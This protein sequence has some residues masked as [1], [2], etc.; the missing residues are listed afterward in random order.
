MILL[1]LYDLQSD[2]C[3]NIDFET[4]CNV[5]IQ[6]IFITLKNKGERET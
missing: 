4:N 2:L 6:K 5:C 3:P 1:I